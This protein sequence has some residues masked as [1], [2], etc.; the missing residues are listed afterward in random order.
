[1][2]DTLSGRCEKHLDAR[3]TALLQREEAGGELKGIEDGDL[4]QWIADCQDSPTKTYHYVL[5]T[6]LLAKCVE[7]SLDARALQSSFDSPGAFDARSVAHSVIVPFDQRNHRV[8]GGSPEP[9]VNNP[10]RYP[11]VTAEYRAQQKN[12]RDWD[13]LVQVLEQVQQ[14]GQDV[15]CAALD[16]VLLEIRRQL[17]QV[18]INYPAPSRISL[19]RTQ[20]LLREYLSEPS[21]GARDEA[22]VAALFR[23]VADRTALF[24]E[25][26]RERVNA[27]DASTGTLADVECYRGGKLML[28]VEVKSGTLTLTQLD[29]SLDKVRAQGVTEFLVLAQERSGDREPDEVALRVQREFVS[30]QNVYVSDLA[31]FAD[32]IL[33]LLGEAGRADL[34]R[35]IGQELDRTDTALPHRQR[36][37]ELLRTL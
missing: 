15:A 3:W 36:W 14:G 12:K 37:A 32:G 11:A 29:A 1:M 28:L 26:R 25:I 17:D 7:P 34:L 31:S 5:P 21:G 9:Y 10:L 4:R 35:E 16:Q 30:G 27:A 6:Q 33:I 13:K 18:R 8:L 23:V 19:R 2:S 22:A 24:D 20:G